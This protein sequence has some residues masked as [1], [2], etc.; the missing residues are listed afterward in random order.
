[1]KGNRETFGSN[2]AVIMAMAGS[3]IGL[4]NIWRFPYLV[5]EYGG[6]AFILV[7]ILASIVLA[8]PIFFAESIIGRRSRANAFGAF[9][10]LAPKGKWHW[11]GLI[12]VVAPLLILSYYN[13]V[14]GWSL[15]YLFKS[16]SLDFVGESNEV[17][18]GYFGGFVSS[19]W[20]PVVP[21]LLFAVGVAAV[22]LGGVKSGIERFTKWTMPLLFVLIVGIVVYS[23]TL[24][25]A[26]EGVR[27]LAKPDWSGLSGKG[28][29]AAM[30]QAFFSLSLGM[31]T[32]LTYSSYMKKQDSILGTGC[33]TAVADMVFAL[34]AGFAVM[35]AVFA[36]GMSHDGGPGLIFCSLPYTFNQMGQSLPLV[37]SIVAI[38][39]FF[40][41]L[42]AALTSAI[43]LLEV[44]V[45]YMS[46]ETH[47]NRK[48]STLL[49]SGIIWVI[50]L[51]WSLSFGPLKGITV[52]G[53]NLFDTVD[54]FCSN[55]LMPLGGLIFTLFVGW[56]MP[57]P[58]VYDEFT[59]GGTLRWS[60]RL[61][62]AFRFL[63]RFVAPVGIVLVSLTPYI[64]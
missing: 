51:A 25:G 56:R 54:Y 20:A 24:P 10:V 29:A 55:V 19:A 16:L 57:A 59:N 37:S 48:Q 60:H 64:F 49:L 22:I 17:V 28:I 27:Y 44:G 26:G 62:P 61:Y 23:V 11:L 58:D 18:T 31:G 41:V 30:G 32:I 43:S 46:E 8:L 42:M 38:L 2:F 34:L 39:F 7:Y 13:V 14:G 36:G 21:H 40:S 6:A 52:A 47:L 4:G 3:A 53:M 35:P 12:T 63:V 33:S 45:A 9:R 1:M 50:G 5:G 15:Q